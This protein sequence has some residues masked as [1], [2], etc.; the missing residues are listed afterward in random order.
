[1]KQRNSG[2]GK[3]ELWGWKQSVQHFSRLEL[4]EKLPPSPYPR[5]GT[6]IYV[7]SDHHL[8]VHR[9][10]PARLHN[11][12]TRLAISH[13]VY[14]EMSHFTPQKPDLIK[15][16]SHEILA[17]QNQRT[18]LLQLTAISVLQHH[19]GVMLTSTPKHPDR[20]MGAASPGPRQLQHPFSMGLSHGISPR[21]LISPHSPCEVKH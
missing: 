2:T 14:S 12:I 13:I 17:R 4:W 21:G 1:M 20:A 15:S 6:F 5:V 19:P 10:C 11:G 18:R 3:E 7:W 9:R 16:I 8:L